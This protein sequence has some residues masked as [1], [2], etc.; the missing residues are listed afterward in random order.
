MTETVQYK[1]TERRTYFCTCLL[2]SPESAP[3]GL[4]LQNC[5]VLSLSTQ[6][7]GPR[8]SGHG[9]GKREEREQVRRPGG[10]ERPQPVARAGSC[11]FRGGSGRLGRGDRLQ[12]EEG[13]LSWGVAFGEPGLRGKAAGWGEA[14]GRA[15]RPGTR[16]ASPRA[17]WGPPASLPQ[18]S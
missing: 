7:T 1:I 15:N 3:F 17:R 5:L 8:K 16:P 9:D 4:W 11:G 12:S 6:E 13:G 14:E 2:F 18:A 10:R